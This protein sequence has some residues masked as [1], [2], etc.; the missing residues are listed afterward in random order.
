M[1]DPETWSW[2]GDPL[3]PPS[4]T[5]ELRARRERELSEA[6][7]EYERNPGDPDAIIW[8]GRR[9]AYI[10]RYREAVAIY[11]EGIDKHPDDPRMYRHRGHRYI[12]LRRLD[13]AIADL[14]QASSMI[15][16]MLSLA[17]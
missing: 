17:M 12:S 16:S 15:E 6:R 14:E 2:L 1:D 4:L 7:A 9:T 10:G 11:T 13:L 5:D 3:A 8:L